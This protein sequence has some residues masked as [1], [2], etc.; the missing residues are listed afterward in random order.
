MQW[1][2]KVLKNY[3]GFEGRAHRTELWMFFLVSF[4]ISIILSVIDS[5]L[6]FESAG[7]RSLYSLVV[8]LPTL[9]VGMRRLH[10]TDRSGWWLLLWLIPILGW[11]PLIIFYCLDGTPGSNQFGPDP[12]RSDAEAI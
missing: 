4:I 1:Y 2:I 8:L 3:V 9:A 7:I 6:G 12:K 10:D 5:V 11:I